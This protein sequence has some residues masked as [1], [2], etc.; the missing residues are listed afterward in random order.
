MWIDAPRTGLIS[1]MSGLL[2]NT[3][4]T[5]PTL[6]IVASVSNGSVPLGARRMS[7]PRETSSSRNDSRIPVASIT[8]SSSIA[9]ATAT[10]ST[11]RTVR[12]RCLMSDARASVSRTQR[13]SR[14]S[15][16]VRTSRNDASTPAAA[17]RKSDNETATATI[18]G[19]TIENSSGVRYSP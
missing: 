10:P 1:R 16:G 11:A 13:P 3:A 2:R 6:G 4:V 7:N 8:M 14:T 18:S 15:G 5:A 19:V 12:A 9:A 17:P